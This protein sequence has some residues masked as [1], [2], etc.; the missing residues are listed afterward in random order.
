MVL[1]HS[2]ARHVDF[3]RLNRLGV[4]MSASMTV[5]LQRK[6]GANFDSKV[7]VWKKEIEKN[8]AAI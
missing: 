7:L 5:A 4:C 8:K 3:Q 2:A 6:M 1:F